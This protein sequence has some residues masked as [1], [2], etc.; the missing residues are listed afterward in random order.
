MAETTAR[1]GLTPQQWDSDF[2][3]E[4]TRESRFKKYVGTNEFSMFHAKEDLPRKPGDKITFAAVRS[5]GGGWPRIMN[6]DG[7]KILR[8]SNDDKYELRVVSFFHYGVRVIN[9]NGRADL[10]G[11]AVT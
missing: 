1:S 10:S 5:L 7:L 6:G 3:T 8:A 4:Y 2:F 11:I 9:M